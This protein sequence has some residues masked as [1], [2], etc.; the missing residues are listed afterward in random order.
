M[1]TQSSEAI[2]DCGWLSNSHAFVRNAVPT[3]EYSAREVPCSSSRELR[4]ACGCGSTVIGQVLCGIS[5]THN[6]SSPFF[7]S[8]TQAFKFPAQDSKLGMAFPPLRPGVAN[9]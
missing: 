1:G 8:T 2:R 6:P 3:L 5:Q 9:S 4:H 7:S